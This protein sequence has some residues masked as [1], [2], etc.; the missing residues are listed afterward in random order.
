[1]GYVT[2]PKDPELLYV[3]DAKGIP[4]SVLSDVRKQVDFLNASLNDSGFAQYHYFVDVR[5]VRV[6]IRRA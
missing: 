5:G 4:Q 6:Y 1:M 2:D 3:G